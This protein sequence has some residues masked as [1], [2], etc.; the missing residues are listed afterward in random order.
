MLAAAKL[1]YLLIER[2]HLLPY[3]KADAI[4]QFRPLAF[5]RLAHQATGARGFRAFPLEVCHE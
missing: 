2:A 5:V 3:A 4:A 1:C